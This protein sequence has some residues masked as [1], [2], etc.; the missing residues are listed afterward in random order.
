MSDHVPRAAVSCIILALFGMALAL[1]F[2]WPV[3]AGA[4][5]ILNVMLG[6]LGTMTAAVVNYWLGSSAGSARKT[7]LLAAAVPIDLAKVP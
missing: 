1:A 6:S 3:P 5:T 7:D 4:E 2:L